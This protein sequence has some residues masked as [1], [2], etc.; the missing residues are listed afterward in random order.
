MIL[1][2]TKARIFIQPGY[3]DMRKAINGLSLHVQSEMKRSPLDG[4]LYVFCGRSR[5]S[6]KIVYWN[7]NGFCLWQKRLED[8][9]F[10]WPKT[11]AEAREINHEELRWFLLGLNFHGVHKEKN[12]SVI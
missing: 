7:R 6:V 11:S 1:D 9:K 4:N 8:D 2:L 12:F 3:T 5:R 10:H